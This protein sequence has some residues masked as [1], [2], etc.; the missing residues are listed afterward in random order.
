MMKK[1]RPDAHRD[2]RRSVENEELVVSSDT[3][4]SRLLDEQEA[5]SVRIEGRGPGDTADVLEDTGI[6]ESDAGE[7]AGTTVEDKET[8]LAQEYLE[9]LQRLQAEF[10][11][12]RKR[13]LKE[14]R[15]SCDSGKAELICRLLPVV[16]DLERALANLKPGCSSE[17]AVKGVKLIYEK[18]KSALHAEGLEG[19]ECR[20]QN[21]DP[22][23]H[24]AVLVTRVEDGRDGEV[25]RDLQKGYTFKG[26][27]IRPSKVEVAQVDDERLD[28]DREEEGEGED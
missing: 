22:N 28:E 18:L 20:G 6:L 5:G 9:H 13:A 14:I 8:G 12:Y 1:K 15:E 10:D 26:R 11:N 24:E 4:R 27:L 2:T 19:I 21:F 3:E 17:E 23:V 16:D 7:S 25:L